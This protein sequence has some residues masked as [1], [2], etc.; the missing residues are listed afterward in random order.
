MVMTD[1]GKMDIKTNNQN[2]GGLQGIYIV[3]NYNPIPIT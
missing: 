2:F 3:S 1:Y